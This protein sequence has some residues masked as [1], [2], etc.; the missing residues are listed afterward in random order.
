MKDSFIYT[1]VQLASHED[2]QH[3]DYKQG[4]VALDHDKKVVAS[5]DLYQGIEVQRKFV[6]GTTPTTAIMKFRKWLHEGKDENY[7]LSF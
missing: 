1:I 5:C 7:I 6:R 2:C 3:E 4:F